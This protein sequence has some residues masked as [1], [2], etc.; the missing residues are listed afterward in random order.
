[1]MAHA[2]ARL[3]LRPGVCMAASGPGVTNLVTGVAHA[4]ADGVPIIAL[5]GSAPVGTWGRG[6]FQDIDQLAMM[7]PCTKWA[8][9]VHHAEAPPGAPERGVP[10]RDVR[11]AGPRLSRSAGR[12]AVPG[13]RRGAGRMAGALGSARRAPRPAGERPR[14]RGA[15]WP[16]SRR[17]EARS[18]IAGSGVLWSEAEAELQA[19]VER[20]GHPVLH[21]AAGPRRDPRGSP[22]L[23]SDRALE[24]VPRGGFD[25]GDRH[26]AE[27][28]DRPRRAAALRCR[29]EDA[30]ASTSTRRDRDQPRQ[31]D[32]GIVGDARTVLRGSC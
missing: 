27:L 18:S 11:Q 12:R 10:P 6:A 28:R 2:Y 19:F 31:L 29:G 5:G 32:L 21:D 30:C 16:C 15:R 26:A 23:L 4:W 9:R 25:P 13:G 1:M 14:G 8:A 22:A 24:R 7:E 20:G 17:R 3:R